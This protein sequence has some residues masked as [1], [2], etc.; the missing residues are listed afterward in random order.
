M[1]YNLVVRCAPMLLAAVAC[2]GAERD[3]GEVLARLREFVHGEKARIPNYT[4]VE[5]IDRVFLLPSREKK[6]RTPKSCPELAE[7]KRTPG[8]R[9]SPNSADRFRLDV[10]VGPDMEMYSWVGAGRFEDRSLQDLLGYGPTSTGS[11]GPVL[12]GI[13]GAD[14]PEFQF[15]G[16]KTVHGLTAYAYSFRVPVEHSHHAF[17]WGGGQVTIAYEGTIYADP[18]TGAPVQLSV[19]VGGL[20]PETACCQFTTELDY[21]HV[22]VG[23]GEFLLP[24]EALQRFVEVN[25]TEV[26]STVTFTSCREYRAESS[27]AYTGASPPAPAASA[28]AAPPPPW[29]AP[30]GLPVSIAL[31]G[32]IDSAVAAA[33]DPFGGRL[34]KPV[35][36]KDKNVI[37]PE[38]AL[39]RGRVTQVQRT[40]DVSRVTILLEVETVEIAGREVP[41]RLTSGAPP[42][43]TPPTGTFPSRGVL[44]GPLPPWLTAGRALFRCSTSR[45]V[46]RDG[47]KTE[48]VTVSRP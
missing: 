30:A 43:P 24:H 31:T 27:V 8:Y 47:Q 36:D 4:C 28:A 20:P 23:A 38:G 9:L 32:T 17:F 15:E 44:I 48:W 34:T 37:A 22:P 13:F 39:V 41:L 2:L 35:V 14:A 11:L 40:L 7:F 5:T 42:I 3:P 26:E 45:C 1:S 46:I 25:G 16:V 12:T 21:R 29:E 33:G 19:F 10:R 6:A 18:R